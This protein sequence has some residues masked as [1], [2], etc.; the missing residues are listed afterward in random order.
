MLGMWLFFLLHFVFLCLF[1]CTQ[2]RKP[3]FGFP[4]D[5]PHSCFL[6][7][8]ITKW[9]PFNS[10]R[11]LQQ[12]N[13]TCE[14]ALYISQSLFY[15]SSFR[16]QSS[17]Y[18]ILIPESSFWLDLQLHAPARLQVQREI[19][20]CRGT[21]SWLVIHCWLATKA[22]QAVFWASTSFSQL[23]PSIFQPQIWVKHPMIQR[24][25]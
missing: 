14:G 15:D 6:C 3:F 13:S 18:L 17:Y 9:H 23:F 7:P 21:F 4:F 25:S 19:I 5:F 2:Q 8:K 22:M 24:R 12:A 20:Y 16:L 1:V 10:C 11:T